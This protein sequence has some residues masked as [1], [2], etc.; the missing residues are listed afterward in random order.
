[1]G[2]ILRLFE[3]GWESMLSLK[4]VS[5][6]RQRVD[7]EVEVRTRERR[8]VRT[9]HGMERSLWRRET[10]WPCCIVSARNKTRQIAS[11]D[12]GR[13]NREGEESASGLGRGRA[14]DET[15]AGEQ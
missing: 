14:E 11:R 1:M 2:E 3:A 9:R 6:K 12:C 5:L 10:P 13:G 4:L 8:V 15:R 7:D